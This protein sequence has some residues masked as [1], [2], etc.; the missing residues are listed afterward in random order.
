MVYSRHI[1]LGAESYSSLGRVGQEKKKILASTFRRF[2]LWTSFEPSPVSV[3]GDYQWSD[4][5]RNRKSGHLT[6]ILRSFAASYPLTLIQQIKLCQNIVHRWT[7]MVNVNHPG[8]YPNH[9]IFKKLSIGMY[10]FNT[11]LVRRALNLPKITFSPEK[12]ELF[13]KKLHVQQAFSKQDTIYINPTLS[14]CSDENSYIISC[15]IQE[16]N[17]ESFYD[18]LATVPNRDPIAIAGAFFNFIEKYV[19]LNLIRLA[20]NKE[21]TFALNIFSNDISL[22]SDIYHVKSTQ[23]APAWEQLRLGFFPKYDGL[24]FIEISDSPSPSPDTGV[25]TDAEESDEV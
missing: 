3:K 11:S 17:P 19:R 8:S 23:L 16:P 10:L 13:D 14:N 15:L 25:Y 7:E 1:R 18:F 2:R 12:L 6:E 22:R 21:L 24:N 9:F 4:L 20:T 5:F